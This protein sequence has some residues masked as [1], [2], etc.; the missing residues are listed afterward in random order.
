MPYKSEKQRAWMWKNRPDIAR[1]WQK[2]GHDYI[3]TKP[4][5]KE[6]KK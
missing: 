6:N 1:Q 4:D 2:K 3:E 5:K